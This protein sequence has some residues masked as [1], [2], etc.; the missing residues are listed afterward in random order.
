V[1][2]IHICPEKRSI[3]FPKEAEGLPNEFASMLFDMSTPLSD[4]MVDYGNDKYDMRIE[5][6]AKAF[7]FN[8]DPTMV[9]MALDIGTKNKVE[10]NR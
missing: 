7:V 3:A 9:I 10:E 5:K 1:L 6:G 4:D 2:N 8:A